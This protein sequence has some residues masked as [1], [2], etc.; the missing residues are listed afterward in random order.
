MQAPNDN[1]KDNISLKVSANIIFRITSAESNE[2]AVIATDPV[3][4]VRAEVKCQDFK[5]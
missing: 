1:F 5:C 4:G 3:V 2:P